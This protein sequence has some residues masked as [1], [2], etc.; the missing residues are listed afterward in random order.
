MSDV[1][2]PRYD[3]ILASTALALILTA[4]LGFAAMA[5]DA[6]ETRAAA[7]STAVSAAQRAAEKF[8]AAGLD[9]AVKPQPADELPA[10][11]PRFRPRRGLSAPA[12]APGQTAMVPKDAAAPSEAPATAKDVA[13]PAVAPA[14]AAKDAAAPAATPATPAV[15]AEQTAPPDPMAALDPADR[16][17]RGKNSR[18]AGRQ[19]ATR[20]RQQERAQRPSRRSIRAAISRRSGSTR[21]SRTRAPRR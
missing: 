21:A 11:S 14:P 12:P 18:P 6:A 2:R 17:G 8:A 3:R 19:A 13:A 15:A 7:P 10:A 4:P 20:L 16:L 9:A 5:Q 1:S